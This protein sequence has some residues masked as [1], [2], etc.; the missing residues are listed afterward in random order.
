MKGI[1]RLYGWLSSQ[2]R[3]QPMLLGFSGIAFEKMTHTKSGAG[4]YQFVGAGVPA[5]EIW[6]IQSAEA[7]DADNAITGIE[8]FIARTGYAGNIAVL[9][10][11]AANVACIYNGQVVL[12]EGDKLKFTLADCTD[13]DELY[14]NYWGMRVDIDQ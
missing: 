7:Y 14:A 4:T 8:I 6:V 2:W 5:G 11:P 12:E 3:A 13:G 10:G 9:V 1:A